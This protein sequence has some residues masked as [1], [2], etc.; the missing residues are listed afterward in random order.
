MH[1]CI[2]ASMH[3]CIH[4]SMY[5]C[6]HACIHAS[7][8]PCMHACIHPSIH[9]CIHPSIDTYIHTHTHTCNIVLIHD[10]CVYAVME[11]M[12]KGIRS[13]VGLGFGI[14]FAVGYC[15]WPW[16][17]KALKSDTYFQLCLVLPN[18]LYYSYIWCVPQVYTIHGTLCIQH[19]VLS[20]YRIHE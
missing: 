16:L 11:F 2:H 7:M 20:L 9:P 17:A 19:A 3:P 18:I 13:A 14:Y 6:I 10:T 12:G 1:P 5:P 15:I 8:H 4:A